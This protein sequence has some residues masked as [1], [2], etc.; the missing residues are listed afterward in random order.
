MSTSIISGPI[1]HISLKGITMFG[2]QFRK[3]RILLQPGTMIL[4]M[5]PLQGS[6]SRS[7]TFPSFLQSLVLITSLHFNSENSISAS[8]SRRCFFIP[9]ICVSRGVYPESRRFFPAMARKTP[10]YFFSSGTYYHCD[11]KQPPVK[12]RRKRNSRRFISPRKED[13]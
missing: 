9:S 11:Q 5:Q 2:S 10:E 7:H 4:Q 8:L 1:W 3:F 12:G 13:A 6:N